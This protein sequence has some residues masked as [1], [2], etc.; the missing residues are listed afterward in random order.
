MDRREFLR[1]GLGSAAAL[2]AGRY[3]DL[4]LIP[5]NMARAHGLTGTAFEFSAREVL[6][7]NVDQTLVYHWAWP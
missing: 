2:V 7:E 1:L 4:P 3:V 6:L 5:A